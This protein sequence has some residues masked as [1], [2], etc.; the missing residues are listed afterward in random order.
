MCYSQTVSHNKMKK[1]T[2][3][4]FLI[5]FKSVADRGGG[6]TANLIFK[7]ICTNMHRLLTNVMVTATGVGVAMHP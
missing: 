5:S 4:T 2:S 3:V 6:G 7:Y 1:N